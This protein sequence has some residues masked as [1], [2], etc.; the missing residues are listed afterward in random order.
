MSSKLACSV[1]DRVCMWERERKR[2]VSKI[3]KSRKGNMLAWCLCTDDD[4]GGDIEK[5][6]KLH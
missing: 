6:R 1:C 2:L 5:E 4:G 3:R